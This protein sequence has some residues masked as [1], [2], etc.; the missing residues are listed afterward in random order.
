MELE[1][2]KK[3]IIHFRENN[4]EKSFNILKDN[5]LKLFNFF[6]RHYN[7]LPLTKE[8]LQSSI[9]VGFY[10][11]ILNYDYQNNSINTLTTYIC[12]SIKNQIFNDLKYIKKKELLILDKNKD[13]DENHSY[14]DDIIGLDEE[15]IFS[16]ATINYKKEIIKEMLNCLTNKQQEIIKYRYG[17]CGYPYKKLEDLSIIFKC[18]K[19]YISNQEHVSLKKMKKN[20][21][22]KYHDL[23]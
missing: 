21:Q 17:I 2:L 1:E 10:K 15:D 3:H 19:Q 18:S 11:A 20:Y 6:L 9:L 13:N 8:E 14:L 16:L 22:N 23:I 4:D 5:Y 7:N 12:K